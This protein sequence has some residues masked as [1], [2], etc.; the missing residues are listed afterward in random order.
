[1][2]L[3]KISFFLI[4]IF[5]L[6]SCATHDESVLNVPNSVLKNNGEQQ[7]KQSQSEAVKE[8]DVIDKYMILEGIKAEEQ[9]KIFENKSNELLNQLSADEDIQIAI[10]EMQLNDFIHLV[11]GEHLGLSYVLDESISKL[12]NETMTLNL[13]EKVSQQKLYSL[14]TELLAKS[15]VQFDSRDSVLF[16]FVNKQSGSKGKFSLGIGREQGDIPTASDERIAQLVPILYADWDSLNQVVG[17]LINIRTRWINER[18]AVLAIGNAKEVGQF[19]RIINTFDLPDVKNKFIGLHE[20]T[21]INVE[22]FIAQITELLLAEGID[23]EHKNAR[24]AFTAL[25]QRN[26]VIVHSANELILNRVAYWTKVLDKPSPTSKKRYYTFNPENANVEDIGE[27]IANLIA[28]QNGQTSPASNKST[29]Q[30]STNNRSNQTKG[31]SAGSAS[32]G[33]A[34]EELSM[35]ISPHQNALVFY[36]TPA[37]YHE[38]LPLLRQMDIVPKQVVIEATIASVT[39]GDSYQQGIEWFLNN[40]LGDTGFQRQLTMDKGLTFSLA[41]VDYSVVLQLLETE[42]RVNILSNPRIV[43]KNGESASL[44]VGQQVPILTQQSS[45]SNGDADTIIQSVQY[46]STGVSL[47]VTPTISGKGVVSLNVAQT[48]SSAL[49][50]NLSD[51]SSPIISDRTITTT[52]LARSG[53][54]IVLGGLIQEDRSVNDSG[55]PFFKDLPFIGNLFLSKSE[56]KTR[57]ELIILLTPKVLSDG[58]DIDNLIKDYSG[59]ATEIQFN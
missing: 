16:F 30:S 58:D 44:N 14:S 6:S 56:D 49:A 33:V 18:N 51:I 42:S 50:N 59:S 12:T 28:L 19:L 11:Y 7:E 27:S 1:M 43:V 45:N 8:N 20:F 15:K 31:A 40:N 39:L 26:A 21:Y 53:Q 41:N 48:V 55:V 24:V 34:T 23:V 29:S 38:I 5:A 22:D 32:S 25:L 52:V 10:N 54:T 46:S 9:A 57:S 3:S 2:P 17:S 37:K 36:T 35:M 13:Q 47:S 4:S